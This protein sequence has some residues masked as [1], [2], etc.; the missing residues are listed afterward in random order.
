MPKRQHDPY[1]FTIE[2]HLRVQNQIE[3]RS[4]ELW[5]RNGSRPGAPL[6][7]WLRAEGEVLREFILSRQV[8]A[9]AGPPTLSGRHR[10]SMQPPDLE[11]QGGAL[12][13]V[14]V[15][16]LGFPDLGGGLV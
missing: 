14:I 9:S 7:D 12:D 11:V 10:K 5:Q 1:Q 4:H 6:P 2:E 16:R 3:K 13:L 8:R 15:P